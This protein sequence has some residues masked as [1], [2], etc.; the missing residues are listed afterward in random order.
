MY[1]SA[2]AN[3]GRCADGLPAKCICG[4]ICTDCASGRYTDQAGQSTCKGY[5]CPQGRAGPLAST[6]SSTATC[7]V[8]EAGRF[9]GDS[10]GA[11]AC[12]DCASGRYTDQAGQSTCKGYACPQGRAGPLAST[13]SSTATCM[14]CEAG[15]F[16]GNSVGASVCLTCPRRTRSA[17]GAADCLCVAG[18]YSVPPTLQASGG[19]CSVRPD[20]LAACS[21]AAAELGLSGKWSAAGAGSCIACEVGRAGNATGATSDAMCTACEAGR[22]SG[23]L[24]GAGACQACPRGKWSAAGAGSCI[25]CEVGR[26]SNATGATSDAMCSACEAGRF[27]GDLVG[28]G[29]C[30]ACPSAVVS[31]LSENRAAGGVAYVS[32]GSFSASHCTLH[33]NLGTT[34]VIHVAPGSVASMRDTM[35]CFNNTPA[36][37][38]VEGAGTLALD[39]FPQHRNAVQ[40]MGRAASGAILI[41]RNVPDAVAL[42][43]TA[44]GMSIAPGLCPA[45]TVQI[46]KWKVSTREDAK[47]CQARSDRRGS[48]HGD[49]V[50]DDSHP[51]FQKDKEGLGPFCDKSTPWGV[52]CLPCP[53]TTALTNTS[54]AAAA[55][56]LPLS[57]RAHPAS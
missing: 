2:G 36:A 45:Y 28:A 8:C 48:A 12:A 1:N 27:S 40:A 37:F 3:T 20:S 39:G 52:R 24:V 35:A 50:L 25:V 17:V 33:G 34:A 19:S 42:K 46:A 31:T 38:H 14:A 5:A 51:C 53:S 47:T 44:S 30:Q 54:A 32:G 6:S 16:S 4:G 41:L 9:S 43:F 18:T 55:V 7:T 56:L 57:L 21:A 13:S 10:A 26:A 23:D 49:K 22:F 11:S 29:A 15:R